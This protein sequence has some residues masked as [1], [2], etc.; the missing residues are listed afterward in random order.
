[1]NILKATKIGCKNVRKIN[2]TFEDAYEIKAH[3]SQYF[4]SSLKPFNGQIFHHK[5]FTLEILKAKVTS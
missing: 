5:T 3:P 4:S 1:M 2:Q